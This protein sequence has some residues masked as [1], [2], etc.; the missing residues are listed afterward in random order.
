MD[1]AMM[2][3]IS[4]AMP[5][6]TAATAT[7]SGSDVKASG[8]SKNDN[9]SAFGSVFG[10]I[11][12]ASNQ[13]TQPA[14]QTAAGEINQL[15]AVLNA[16]SIEEVLDLL[17]IPHDDGLLMLQIGED[18][19]AVA[20]DEMLNLENLMGA[21][22]IDS[23]QLQKLVQKL[24]G[25]DKEAKDV[26]ELLALVDVQAPVL[27]AQVVTALQG[28]GQVTPKEAT[29]LLQVLKLAQL[30]GQKT[31]LTAPQENL[32]TNVKSLLTVLQTNVETIQ[33]TPQVTTKTTVTLPLQGFQHVVQ[34][35]QVTKQT[36]TSANEMVTANTVQTKAD[37][38]Q[39]TLPAAKPAQ[40]EAL[41]KE[42]QA[43]M[44]KAQISNVQGITRL[45]LKLY[46]ENLGTIRIELVQNDGVL[47]AR[48]LASTAHGRELLDSQAHQ[49][50][51]AFVQQNIQIERLD[52]AQSLQDADRQ[53]RDQSFFSNFFKQQ[54]QEE[55]EQSTEDDDEGK[56]FNDYLISEEV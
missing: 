35:V 55:Q 6:K 41:L 42:M 47:T 30:V 26:W 15:A 14:Q 48:L 1:V 43:I 56:S 32:L 28:E 46:P 11:M 3:M 33:T 20:M 2:Q 17:D 38:F 50:K 23:E 19:K 24:L 22:G 44:N 54:Q 5:P 37:T 36:D 49:L 52:I 13:T 27:Q 18:G 16:E 53:Q 34:Q 51:Q 12:S 25:E 40:S 8:G 45:T 9:L 31:D 7:N 29:Q 21:L 10:Q 39:V 4:K